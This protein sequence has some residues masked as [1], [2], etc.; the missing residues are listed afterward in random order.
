MSVALLTIGIIFIGYYIAL[1]LYT[2]NL[3]SSFTWVWAAVGAA[4]IL[5]SRYFAYMKARG[6]SVPAR[7]LVPL[8]I[9]FLGFAISFVIVEA[10]VMKASY[11]DRSFRALAY[12]IVLGAQVRGERITKCLRKRLDTAHDYWEEC[13]TAKIIVTVRG[14]AEEARFTKRRGDE[15][16]SV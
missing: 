14:G 12:L 7:V 6:E 1:L 15:T 9:I 10:V 5:L 16:L 8:E 2:R 13:P 11:Q 4:L 3:K